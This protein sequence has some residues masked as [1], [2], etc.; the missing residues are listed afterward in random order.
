MRFR[1]PKTRL[2]GEN[3]HSS[4]RVAVGESDLR[5]A[6]GEFRLLE[7]FDQ[8]L[9]NHGFHWLRIASCDDGRSGPFR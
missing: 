9:R 2:A 5:G 8:T 7:S 4:R 6:D 1:L 3:V